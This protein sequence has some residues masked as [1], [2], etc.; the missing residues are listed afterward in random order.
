[1][2]RKRPRRTRERILETALA[3][4][5]SRGEPGVTTSAIAEEMNISP[6]TFCSAWVKGNLMPVPR[7]PSRSTSAFSMEEES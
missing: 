6:A 3:L 7:M 5:N 2:E 4:F 1:M